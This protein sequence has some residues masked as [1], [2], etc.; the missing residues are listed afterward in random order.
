MSKFTVKLHKWNN[1]VL[2]WA[3]HK[4][5]TRKEAEEFAVDSDHHVAKVFNEYG[6][7]INEVTKQPMPSEVIPAAA[8]EITYA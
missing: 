3:E 5:H 7:M 8:K 6:N 1:G 4:F 2:T